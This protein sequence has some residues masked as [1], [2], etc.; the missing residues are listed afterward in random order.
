MMRCAPGV[1]EKAAEVLLGAPGLARS[2]VLDL[3]A[4]SG[5]FL[6]R[7]RD[8]GFADLHA[9]EI[10]GGFSLDGVA[11]CP[12]DLNTDFAKAIDRRFSVITA[13]EII[14]H[15]DSP[16]HFLGQVRELLEPGGYLLV[17]TPN[18]SSWLGRIQFLMSGDLR[19]FDR[20]QYDY[21]RH[22]SPM[23]HTHM[24]LMLG[25]LGFDL[26][27]YTTA[28]EYYGPLKRVA[29]APLHLPLRLFCGPRVYGD[30]G[31]YLAT[32]APD[33]GVLAVKNGQGRLHATRPIPEP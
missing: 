12:V 3:A 15:L 29:T 11:P 19:Y 4:G 30:V 2:G 26:L 31:I 18:V 9:V 16:R 13:T 25:E 17:S 10:G 23:T 22:V 33:Q 1:H 14:E 24:E 8:L 6:Q 27:Q 32:K 28:G 21:Q 7:L 5:A 20:H